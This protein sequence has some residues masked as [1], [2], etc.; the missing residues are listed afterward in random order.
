MTEPKA[1]SKKQDEEK[2][3]EVAKKKRIKEK[4][5]E[6]KKIKEEEDER[7]EEEKAKKEEKKEVAKGGLQLNSRYTI[8]LLVGAA[9][10]ISIMVCKLMVPALSPTLPE[11]TALLG[12]IASSFNYSNSERGRIEGLIPDTSLF[13][14]KLTFDQERG[15]VENELDVVGRELNTLGNDLTGVRL[16]LDS[17]IK[18]LVEYNLTG[19]FGNYTLEARVSKVGNFTAR[20]NCV[21][22]PARSIGVANSTLEEAI[23]DFNSSWLA[24]L[25]RNYVP[26][27]VYDSQWKVSEVSF[28]TGKFSLL[29]TNSTSISITFTGL[30]VTPDYVF[31][32]V[33]PVI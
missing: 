2:K 10:L 25:D 11:Y 13:V 9:I 15:E 16:D 8:F 29:T 5:R 6:W 19:T 24:S 28:L 3:K 17:R 27:L 30:N 7:E 23:L 1:K 21:Y 31:A 14:T 22:S 18:P 20:L 26:N 32:E 12:D 33:L 4:E